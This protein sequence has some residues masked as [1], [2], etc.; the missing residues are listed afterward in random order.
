MIMDILDQQPV[1]A[2]FL[3]LGLILLVL[4][5]II[6]WTTHISFRINK[7]DPPGSQPLFA[8]AFLQILLGVITLLIVRAIKNEPLISI[9]SGLA[10]TL[11]SELFV[12]KWMLKKSWKQALRLWAVAAALQL[13]ALPVSS[14]LMLVILVM[15]LTWIYPPQF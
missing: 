12:I 5:M 15:V 14:A 11:L 2:L 1:I 3:G 4:C 7:L 10:L 6:S 8:A 9:S 13:V